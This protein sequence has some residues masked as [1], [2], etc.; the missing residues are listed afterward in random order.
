MRDKLGQFFCPEKSVC[1]IDLSDIATKGKKRRKTKKKTQILI[2]K[3]RKTKHIENCTAHSK[4]SY[5]FQA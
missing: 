3:T 1:K 5:Y 2:I 4:M